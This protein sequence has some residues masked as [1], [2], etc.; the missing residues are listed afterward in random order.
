MTDDINILT[1]RIIKICEKRKWSLHWTWRCA[2]LQLE[3]SEMFE[4]IRGKH[5]NPT[6]EAGDVL[7]GFLA[8]TG[9]NN[10]KWQDILNAADKKI[11]FLEQAPRYE[12]EEYERL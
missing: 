10:I 5:G 12:G 11:S 8:T 2:N 9:A 7:I 6:E 3:I 4:A 1:H